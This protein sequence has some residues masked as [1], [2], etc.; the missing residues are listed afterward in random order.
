[1]SN[2]HEDRACFVSSDRQEDG[3]VIV[4]YGDIWWKH[5]G[6]PF[7]PDCKYEPNEGILED[8]VEHLTAEEYAAKFPK[9]INMTDYFA[10]R[11]GYSSSGIHELV[12]KLKASASAHDEDLDI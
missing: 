3:S 4:T 12:A 8:F 7:A 5:D 1:M 9:V 6:D 11:G 10:S 2:P